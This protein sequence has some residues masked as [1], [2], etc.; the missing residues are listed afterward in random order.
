MGQKENK[1]SKL[2]RLEASQHGF[3]LFRN[4]RGMFWTLDSIK[5]VGGKYYINNP[6]KIRAGLEGNGTPDF[7]GWKPVT[8]TPDMVGKQ[9]AVFTGFEVKTKKGPATKAQK[10]FIELLGSHGGIS[11]I[12]RDPDDVKKILDESL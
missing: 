2:V 1:V 9:L 11:G 10:K 7:V 4:N 3:R 5:E 12:T 6:R 8:I